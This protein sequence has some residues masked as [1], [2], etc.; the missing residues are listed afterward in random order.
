MPHS[1]IAVIPLSGDLTSTSD[2]THGAE[3]ARAGAFV[4]LDLRDVEWVESV[5][6]G[7]LVQAIA[8][9]RDQGGEVVLASARPRVARLLAQ[10]GITGNLCRIFDTNEAARRHLERRAS[11]GA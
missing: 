11:D 2:G 9:R 5:G 1:E 8:E 10:M 7:F 4:I 6:I 3:L